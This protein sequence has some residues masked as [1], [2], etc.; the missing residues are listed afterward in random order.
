M[1]TAAAWA[2][3]D[4]ELYFRIL[5]AVAVADVLTVALQPFLARS[6][7][8]TSVHHV[9]LLVE[10]GGERDVDV[11]APTFAA[12]VAKAVTGAEQNGS[13]VVRIERV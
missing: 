13:R 5:A 7:R 12:A 3:V 10:P 1:I 6:S 4:N 11:E 2:E 8:S 9:R